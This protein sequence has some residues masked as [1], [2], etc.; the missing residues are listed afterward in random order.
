[1]LERMPRFAEL[2]KDRFDG[3]PE[4]RA[5]VHFAQVRQLVRDDVVDDRHREM[6]QPPV[7]PD[8][9]VARATAP[10]DESAYIEYVTPSFSA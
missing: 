9:A 10:A 5:V 8:L 7:Q 6:D 4:G 3:L 2:G 1:M